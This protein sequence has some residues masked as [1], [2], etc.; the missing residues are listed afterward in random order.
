M[1]I[2]AFPDDKRSL[3]GGETGFLADISVSKAKLSQKPGFW[4]HAIASRG[5]NR[6]SC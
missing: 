5:R 1:E 6:V 3:G 4:H 2:I